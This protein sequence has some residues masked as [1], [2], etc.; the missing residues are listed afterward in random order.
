MSAGA[1]VCLV[2]FAPRLYVAATREPVV[3]GDEVSYVSCAENLAAGNG[4]LVGTA[5]PGLRLFLPPAY[6]A[7]LAPFA[8]AL[9]AGRLVY[10]AA[11]A[12][13]VLG[14]ATAWLAF[15]VA[16][17]GAGNAAGVAAG[18][19]VA[20]HPYFV[21]YS[22]RLLTETLAL[23]LF[24]LFLFFYTD[25]RGG[26]GR[27]AAAGATLGFAALTRPTFFYLAPVVGLALLAGDHNRPRP[28][29]RRLADLACLAAAFVAVVAP[30]TARNAALSKRFIAINYVTGTAFYQKNRVLARG[31]PRLWDVPKTADYQRF[32]RGYSGPLAAELAF[33]DYLRARALEF[34]RHNKTGFVVLSFRRLMHTFRPFPALSPW[35]ART[36]KIMAG[37]VGGGIFTT[38]LFAGATLGFAA[39]PPSRLKFTLGAAVLALTFFHA[40]TIALLRYRLPTDLALAVAGGWGW[41]FVYRTIKKRA[42]R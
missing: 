42:G 41:A 29:R 28:W 31:A 34:I 19:A 2:A 23:F 14:A 9:P 15:A 12:Q 25:E 20:F 17:R 21:Y 33:Q 3:S 6:P 36:P 18:L 26:M 22:G 13:A 16:R 24:A 1:A 11:A 32:A 10:G 40:V 39:M 37:I 4:F 5:N 30:W 8:A 38:V 27:L 7:F 35:V